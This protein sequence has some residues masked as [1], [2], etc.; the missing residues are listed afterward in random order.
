MGEDARAHHHRLSHR[1]ACGLAP[2][3]ARQR[4]RPDCGTLAIARTKNG[5]PIVAALS[6]DAL[7]ELKRLPKIGPDE[8]IFGNRSGKPFTYR[9]LWLRITEEARLPGR[10]FHEL[11][12]GHGYQLPAPAC[13]SS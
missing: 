13:L 8:L 2:R 12:H 4:R 7:A 1:P 9:P 5:D 10:V 6:S 11:R 3:R